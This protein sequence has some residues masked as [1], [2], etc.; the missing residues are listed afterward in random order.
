MNAMREFYHLRIKVDLDVADIN[1]R[2]S[3]WGIGVI[4]VIN[5]ED[6]SASKNITVRQ[7]I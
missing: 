5:E 2:R 1:V 4:A 7:V 3:I 6:F